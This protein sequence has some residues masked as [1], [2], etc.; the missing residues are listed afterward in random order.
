[1]ILFTFAVGATTTLLFALAPALPGGARARRLTPCH[2]AAAATAGGRQLLQ[3]CWS[4][5]RSPSPSA[6]EPARA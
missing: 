6:A 1:M 5:L 4:A 3:R 2:V